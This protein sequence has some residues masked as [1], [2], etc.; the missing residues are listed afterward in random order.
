MDRKARTRE[1]SRREGHST[2]SSLSPPRASIRR[3]EAYHPGCRV[4]S[5]RL[6][7]SSASRLHSS[8]SFPR[9]ASVPIPIRRAL[10]SPTFRGNKSTAELER[11]YENSTWGMYDR[12][13]KGRQR[14]HDRNVLIE[15]LRQIELAKEEMQGQCQ[16]PSE[17]TTSTASSQTSSGRTA[18]L[19]ASAISARSQSRSPSQIFTIGSIVGLQ[20]MQRVSG[21]ESSSSTSAEAENFRLEL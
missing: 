16:P 15:S 2:F 5:R 6:Q 17:S 9:P 3:S 10:S 12:I 13:V 7:S 19:T 18:S 11:M 20:S 4:R 14:Q 21:S 8:L 1:L